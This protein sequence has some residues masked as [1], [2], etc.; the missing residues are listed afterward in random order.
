MPYRSPLHERDG[1]LP[2]CTGALR[3][4]SSNLQRAA[5]V[6]V[7]AQENYREVAQLPRLRR[8]RASPRWLDTAYV[9]RMS[10]ATARRPSPSVH[11]RASTFQQL[12]P[13]SSRRSHLRARE[14]ATAYSISGDG[15]ARA[16]AAHA[17]RAVLVGVGPCPIAL[18]KPTARARQ[19]SPSVQGHAPTC[20]QR[21]PPS[22]VR[23]RVRKGK[24]A[25]TRSLSGGGAAR[26]L[27]VRA[28][29]AALVGSVPCPTEAHYASATALF[30]GARLRSD[31]STMGSNKQPAFACAHRRMYHRALSLSRWRST[32]VCGARA[33]RR[34][35]WTRSVP[36]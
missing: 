4:A 29:S 22:G 33:P 19:L 18:W 28:R 25:T 21:P 16:L 17:R 27:A 26:A 10:T 11:G 9:L 3:R 15:A 13:T 35:C 7:C 30:L 8:A 14:R 23:S 20:Q 32:S 2:R 5:G 34:T 6:R 31:V 12:T 1:P 36:L 24:Y